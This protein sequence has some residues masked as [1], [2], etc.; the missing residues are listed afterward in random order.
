[1]DA[2]TMRCS[3]IDKSIPQPLYFLHLFKN[4][5]IMKEFILE[6]LH[7]E[8]YKNLDMAVFIKNTKS[9]Y[10]WA[11]DFFVKKSAGLCSVNEVI[12]K[13]DHDFV[14]HDFADELTSNDQLLFEKKENLNISERILRYEG[15]QIDLITKKHPLFDKNKQLMGLMGFSM[16]LPVSPMS[17]LLSKREY[18]AVSLMSQGYT[19]KKIAKKWGISH[20]TVETY[21]INAKHKL[22]M[23]TRAELI[24]KFCRSHP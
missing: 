8:A 13:Q 2:Y 1:M 11:N 15:N 24:A 22:G 16:E 9:Q 6:S 18:D 19:D 3:R 23:Q 21:I 12:N 10:L 14:W 5:I 17:R 4:K 7:L 20:R